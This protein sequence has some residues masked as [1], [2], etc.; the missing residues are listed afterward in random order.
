MRLTAS[1][2]LRLETPL[3]IDLINERVHADDVVGFREAVQAAVKARGRFDH[4]LRFTR[5]GGDAR[6]LHMVGHFLPEQPEQFVG[7]LIDVTDRRASEEALRNSEY[8]YRNLF[9]A[10]AASFWELDFS[11]VGAMLRG[12]RSRRREG[13]RRLFRRAS[14]VC[15]RDDARDARDRRQRLD[16]R[17]LRAAATRRNCWQCR[18]FVAGGVATPSM[19]PA[20][21]PPSPASRA[22]PPSARMRTIDGREF[23]RAVHGLLSRRRPLPTAGC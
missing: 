18:A 6:I 14:R 20:S 4:E 22:S 2:A 1:V 3:S 17:A 10:M 19:P 15:P 12:L 5:D 21:S 11:G 9:Q 13:L 23:R 16:R 8:R 7:A